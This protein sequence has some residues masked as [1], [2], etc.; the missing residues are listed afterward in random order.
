MS[1]NLT[2][3]L[4][5]AAQTGFASP[6]YTLTLDVAPDINGKQWAVSAIG[7]T[8]TGVT[9]H[10]VASPFTICFWRPKLYK[11]LGALNSAGVISSVPRNV[12]KIVT[13]KGVTP[14][15]NQSSTPLVV[16]TTVEC[17][18]GA[19]TFD[20]PNVRAALSAHFGAVA[21]SSAGIGDTVVTGIA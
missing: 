19:D 2:S 7:G 21:Q 10:S 15:A 14:A 5:G 8:Q 4:T 1:E 6:T 17:P 12:H 16:T 18:A 11:L 9:T 13:R 3:P 20:A